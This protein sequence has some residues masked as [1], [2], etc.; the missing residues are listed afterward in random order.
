MKKI[1]LTPSLEVAS[2]VLKGLEKLYR[3]KKNLCSISVESYSNGREQGLYLINQE[4]K[5]IAISQFRNSDDIVVYWG[6]M[7]DFDMWGNIPRNELL[8]TQTQFFKRKN[9]LRASQFI[10]NYFNGR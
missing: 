5:S 7:D 3:G 10:F 1:K 2:L 4:D 6:N 9:I 8:E